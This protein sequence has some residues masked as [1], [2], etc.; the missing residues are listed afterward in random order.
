MSYTKFVY[1]ACLINWQIMYILLGLTLNKI[2][3]TLR[4]TKPSG[5]RP[6]SPDVMMWNRCLRHPRRMPEMVGEVIWL[7]NHTDS[8]QRKQPLSP[9]KARTPPW[10]EWR[11][12]VWDWLTETYGPIERCLTKRSANWKKTLRL[13]HVILS[14]RPL[15]VVFLKPISNRLTSRVWRALNRLGPLPFLRNFY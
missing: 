15:S 4:T 9:S 13:Q 14:R 8:N 11:T 2:L 7:G 1:F 6:N 12:R 3:L 5:D 10:S